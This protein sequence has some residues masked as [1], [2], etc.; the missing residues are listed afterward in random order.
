[1]GTLDKTKLIEVLDPQ[2]GK[3][4]ETTLERGRLDS[5]DARELFETGIGQKRGRKWTLLEIE[6][7]ALHTAVEQNG[8]TQWAGRLADVR[9]QR[10]VL[11]SIISADPTVTLADNMRRF[12]AAEKIEQY[13]Q[14]LVASCDR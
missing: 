1:M 10:Q 4:K 7:N 2:A 9:E 11:D 13:M 8:L 14:G 12:L 3:L 5:Q 6:E